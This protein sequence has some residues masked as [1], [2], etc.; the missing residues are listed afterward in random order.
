LS[1]AITKFDGGV[2]L[3]KDAR[4]LR[5]NETPV[6]LNV[7]GTSDSLRP[8]RNYKILQRLDKVGGVFPSITSIIQFDPTGVMNSFVTPLNTATTSIFVGTNQNTEPEET[9]PFPDDTIEVTPILPNLS[10]LLIINDFNADLDPEPDTGPNGIFDAT[11]ADQG[12]PGNPTFI[13][14]TSV[15]NGHYSTD[16]S[17][18]FRLANPSSSIL[19]HRS[20]T[21]SIWIKTSSGFSGV[22]SLWSRDNTAG[23]RETLSYNGTTDTLTF[24]STNDT[25]STVSKAGAGLND[26]NFHHLLAFRNAVDGPGGQGRLALFIDGGPLSAAVVSITV[27]ADYGSFVPGRFLIGRINVPGGETFELAMHKMWNQVITGETVSEAKTFDEQIL[28]FA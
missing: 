22:G 21:M 7:E 3:S 20:M 5:D 8:R 27:G 25:P 16:I 18:H 23:L 26:G 28:F 12:S 4:Y 1:N 24:E 19:F 14:A 15:E 10:G 2:V 9:T 11:H 17:N 6:A 13:V